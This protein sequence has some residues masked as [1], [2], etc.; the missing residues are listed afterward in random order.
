MSKNTPILIFSYLRF[1]WLCLILFQFQSRSNDVRLSKYQKLKYIPQNKT[2]LRSMRCNFLIRKFMVHCLALWMQ[3]RNIKILTE[4]VWIGKS[5]YFI[6]HRFFLLRICLQAF[7]AAYRIV[8]NSFSQLR[9]IHYK[10]ICVRAGSAA[11]V[12][13]IALYKRFFKHV[14]GRCAAQRTIR[15]KSASQ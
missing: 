7:M 8:I 3:N 10:F 15:H 13:T 11:K 6:P 12:L 14:S 5:V 9:W 2:A 1:I 4:S